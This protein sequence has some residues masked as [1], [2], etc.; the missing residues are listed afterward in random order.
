G[1]PAPGGQREHARAGPAGGFGHVLAGEPVD[2][3]VAEHAQAGGGG[4]DVRPVPPQPAQPGWGGDG[5]PV[6]G[7]GVD[8]LRGALA[9][10]VLRLG[11]GPAVHVGAREDLV[12]GGLVQDHAL[13]HARRRDGRHVGTGRAHGTQ[14]VPDTGS[15]GLPARVDVEV[16][17]A[18]RPGRLAVGPLALPHGGLR[19][20]LGEQHG[21]AAAGARVDGQQVAPGHRVPC[22]TWG[23][24]TLAG[25]R[26]ASSSVTAVTARCAPRAR[27]STVAPP[28]C[29]VTNT[30]GRFS[31]GWRPGVRSS[32]SSAAPP[33][34]PVSSAWRRAASSTSASRAVL[35]KYAPR[36]I[37]ANR[38][39]ENIRPFSGVRRA[40][41]EIMSERASS[42][43][44]DTS[45][46]PGSS[47]RAGGTGS[48]PSTA[49]PSARARRAT[50]CPTWPSPTSPMVRLGASVPKNSRPSNTDSAKPRPCSR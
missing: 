19:A 33:S 27:V 16:R 32:T 36:R 11:G 1:R 5:H 37:W 35:M 22:R 47:R 4:E 31:S 46:T 10:E 12:P 18:G 21:P 23:F 26:P 7:L 13:A 30:F 2:D 49:K 41:S 29:G 20:G 40:C 15:N 8:L 3:P 28:M 42:P 17:A 34:R 45:S 44:R 14:R 25:T 50:S 9:D 43:S 24:T 48:Y 38:S 39:R 6:A